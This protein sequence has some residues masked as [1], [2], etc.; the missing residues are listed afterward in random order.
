MRGTCWRPDT[1]RTVHLDRGQNKLTG[2]NTF[3]RAVIVS[4]GNNKLV[5]RSWAENKKQLWCK[6]L[7]YRENHHGTLAEVMGEDCRVRSIIGGTEEPHSYEDWRRADTSV[8]SYHTCNV[9]RFTFELTKFYGNSGQWRG[10]DSE[11]CQTRSYATSPL[12]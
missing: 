5:G 11:N 2:R 4:L 8:P 7:G 3:V 12:L 6:K 1:R 10:L 9:G